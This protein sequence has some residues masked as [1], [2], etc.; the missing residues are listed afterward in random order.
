MRSS[1]CGRSQPIRLA[2]GFPLHRG[3]PTTRQV[4]HP[5]HGRLTSPTLPATARIYHILDQISVNQSAVVN[6]RGLDDRAV[7]DL[8]ARGSRDA[9]PQQ[10]VGCLIGRH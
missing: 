7:G 1:G 2:A 5:L 10:D 6:P 8:R 4:L 3:L 9:H